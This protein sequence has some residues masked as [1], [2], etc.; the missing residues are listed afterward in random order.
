MNE[1]NDDNPETKYSSHTDKD[2]TSHTNR[3]D[4]I[5][6]AKYTKNSNDDD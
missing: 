3:D 1:G 4:F 2:Y 5:A 6:K